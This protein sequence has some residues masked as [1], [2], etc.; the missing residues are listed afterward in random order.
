KKSFDEDAKDIKAIKPKDIYEFAQNI[1]I[2]LHNNLASSPNLNLLSRAL[3]EKMNLFEMTL[4]KIVSLEP[5]VELTHVECEID[6]SQSIVSK[7]FEFDKRFNEYRFV[8][9]FAFVN[10]EDIKDMYCPNSIGFLATEENTKDQEFRL[11]LKELE[12]RFPTTQLIAFCFTQY[13]ISKAHETFNNELYNIKYLIPENIL[14]LANQVEFYVHN[15]KLGVFTKIV[16]FLDQY[17]TNILTILHTF[18]AKNSIALQANPNQHQQVIRNLSPLRVKNHK[19]DSYY[20]VIYNDIMT[21]ISNYDFKLNE[22]KTTY[23]LRMYDDIRLGLQFNKFKKI[24]HK[25]KQVRMSMR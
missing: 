24:Y 18:K 17:A 23:E 16:K 5:K 8:N 3:K 1:E 22:E 2:F 12:K 13:E 10:K 7:I 19:S 9:T 6:F 4:T 21:Q 25:I 11:Y 20:D 14:S 15:H